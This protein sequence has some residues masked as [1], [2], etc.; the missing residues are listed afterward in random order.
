M[1]AN[2]HPFRPSP[3]LFTGWL[4]VRAYISNE[5]SLGLERLETFLSSRSR[6]GPKPQTPRFRLGLG[7]TKSRS[8][9]GLAVQP[10]QCALDAA[11]ETIIDLLNV[12]RVI[13]ELLP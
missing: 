8:R 11:T 9:L 13:Q 10:V 6:L 1:G 12:E 7:P 3:P 5:L 4:F 2:L